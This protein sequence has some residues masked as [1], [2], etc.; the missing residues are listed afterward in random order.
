ML[1]H[2]TVRLRAR[3][4]TSVGTGWVKSLECEK[5]WIEAGLCVQRLLTSFPVGVG[6]GIK[7]T[8]RIKQK[9]GDD[10]LIGMLIIESIVLLVI[11]PIILPAYR[12]FAEL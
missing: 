1:I 10:K 11:L 2:A 6:I 5:V 8:K 3:V 12:N 4:C 7:T 9:L